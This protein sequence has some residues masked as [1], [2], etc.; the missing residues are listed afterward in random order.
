M[1]K[2]AKIFNRRN[3]ERAQKSERG[4]NFMELA[5]SLVFL[6]MLLSVVIDLGWAF[7]QMTALRDVAQEAA[8]YGIMCPDHDAIVYRLERSTTAPLSAEDIQDSNITVESFSMGSATPWKK[9]SVVKVS[10][11]YPHDIM[12]PF[13]GAVIDTTTYPLSVDI[14]DTI[15]V[16]KCPSS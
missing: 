6:L 10:L 7:Y 14:S 12:V 8:S 4:Q 9:G 5:V 1:M 11:T 2:K 16:D 3:S 13:L 15:M